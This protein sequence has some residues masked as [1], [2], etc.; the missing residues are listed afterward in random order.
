MDRRLELHDELLSIFE[1]NVYYQPPESI[2]LSYPCFIYELSGGKK[3]Q[4]DDTMYLFTRRYEGTYITRDPDHTLIETLLKHFKHI[5]YDRRFVSNNL[6][7]DTF[8]IYY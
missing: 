3:E 7:H 2:K 1:N 5:S 6:Y 8:T 4:A